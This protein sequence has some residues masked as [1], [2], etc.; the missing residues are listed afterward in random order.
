MELLAHFTAMEWP[1][2]A[3]AFVSGIAVGV[4]GVAALWFRRPR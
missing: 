2:L 1:A 4:T 3:V